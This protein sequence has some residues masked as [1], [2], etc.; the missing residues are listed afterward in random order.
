VYSASNNAP[1]TKIDT[2]DYDGKF[3]TWVTNGFAGYVMLNGGKFSING[4]RGLLRPKYENINIQYIKSVIEPKLRELAKGR[5]G[6]KGEDEFTKVYPSM[7]ENVEIEMFVDE[8]GGFDIEKQNEIAEKY[9]YFNELNGEIAEYK[10]QIEELNVEIVEQ[11]EI[12]KSDIKFIKYK[13]QY[14]FEILGEDNITKK[15]INDHKGGYPVYSGQIENGGIFG[16]INTYKYD[17]SLLTWVTY[18]NSGHIKKID[19]KFNIG[20]N[21]CG[22]RPKFNNIDLDYI[23]F[24]VQPIFI[25][26]VKGNKQKSLPQSIVKK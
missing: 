23:R 5:K 11:N 4:D 3:L 6:E 19:G 15:Y 21:N 2:F 26:N 24:I 12:N 22:L 14:L 10:K 17:E 7:I 18:G 13:V 1:L 9:E 25:E 20:R 16:Y 8:N